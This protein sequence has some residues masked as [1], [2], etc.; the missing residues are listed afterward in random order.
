MAQFRRVL[1]SLLSLLQ[2]L[3]KQLASDIL[4]SRERI[5]G[6]LANPKTFAALQ[7]E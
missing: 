5:W 4:S 7:A 6:P 1:L 2:D 3:D